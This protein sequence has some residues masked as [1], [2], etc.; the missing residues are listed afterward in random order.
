MGT[1]GVEKHSSS[2]YLNM[3]PKDQQNWMEKS[4]KPPG[5]FDSSCWHQRWSMFTPG[6]N[7]NATGC[8]GTHVPYMSARKKKYCRIKAFQWLWLKIRMPKRTATL[9]ISSFDR[10]MFGAHGPSTTN[11]ICM[12]NN[13]WVASIALRVTTWTANKKPWKFRKFYRELPKSGPYPSLKWQNQPVDLTTSWCWCWYQ[14][15]GFLASF[16]P[17]SKKTYFPPNPASNREGLSESLSSN[18]KKK[19][20]EG[21][22]DN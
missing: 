12:P 6:K 17:P 13:R 20:E 9:A 5:L 1:W 7:S 22:E 3:K 11:N 21:F 19:G 18:L 16:P 10:C 8:I 15:S 14:I 2:N 4:P